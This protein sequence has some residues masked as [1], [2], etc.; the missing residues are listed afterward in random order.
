MGSVALLCAA[1]SLRTKWF[2]GPPACSIA[3][4][5]SAWRPCIAAVT[6]APEA[7]GPAVWIGRDAL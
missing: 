3:A 4:I 7:P 1:A 5:D 2:E 6:S